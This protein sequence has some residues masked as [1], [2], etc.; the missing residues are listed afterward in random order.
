M[1]VYHC[2][3]IYVFLFCVAVHALKMHQKRLI[4][5]VNTYTAKY[6]LKHVIKV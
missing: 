4:L 6:V 2:I 5:V 1:Y 3:L